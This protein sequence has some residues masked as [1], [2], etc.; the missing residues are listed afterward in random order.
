MKNVVDER[1]S[2]RERE[3][4]KDTHTPHIH[5]HLHPSRRGIIGEVTSQTTSIKILLICA[6]QYISA[7]AGHHP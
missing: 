1:E 7:S 2:K 6:E 4:I 5:T 3:K